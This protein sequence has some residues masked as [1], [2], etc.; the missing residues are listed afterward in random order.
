MS[1][2]NKL[3]KMLEPSFKSKCID[4]VEMEDGLVR[5]S[6]ESLLYVGKIQLISDMLKTT[7][8]VVHECSLRLA[9]VREVF[10]CFKDSENLEVVCSYHL[11]RRRREINLTNEDTLQN[12]NEKYDCEQSQAM[13]D[14]LFLT[15]RVSRKDKEIKLKDVL[16]ENGF[17]QDV[18]E[19]KDVNLK[20]QK[21]KSMSRVKIQDV[22]EKTIIDVLGNTIGKRSINDQ[23]TLDSFDPEIIIE[24]GECVNDDGNTLTHFYLS[25]SIDSVTA[26]HM[27]ILLRSLKYL[28][29][30]MSL[31]VSD[32]VYSIDTEIAA[33]MTWFEKRGGSK[34]ENLLKIKDQID[35]RNPIVRCSLR[36]TV[37]NMDKADIYKLSELA[38]DLFGAPLMHERQVP[39]HMISSTLLGNCTREDLKAIERSRRVLLSTLGNI[40][41]VYTGSLGY[42]EGVKKTSFDGTLIKIDRLSG[43]GNRMTTL[44]GNSGSGKSVVLGD[45]VAEFCQKNKCGLVRVIDRK[46]TLAGLSEVLNGD[47]KRLSESKGVVLSPF[48]IETPDEGDI[49]AIAFL[50]ITAMKCHVSSLNVTALFKE[51]LKEAI[52]ISYG[53]HT[54]DV[55][56][57][58]P[59]PIWQDV[60]SA[61]PHVKDVY[62]SH[63]HDESELDEI[64]RTIKS[65]GVSLESGGQFGQI[66]SGYDY[67]GI[68]KKQ[69]TIYDLDG[70]ADDA[71]RTLMYMTTFIKVMRDIK[72][73]DDSLPKL[74]VF[75]EFGILVNQKSAQLEI[76]DFVDEI[77]KTCRKLNV[78]AIA[79]A[80]D[81]ATYSKSLA[82]RAFW[83]ISTLKIFLPLG[84]LIESIKSDFGDLF[85]SLDYEC[86]EVLTREFDKRRTLIF[87]RDTRFSETDIKR[88]VYYSY[89][90]E[91]FEN[92]MKPRSGFRQ[93]VTSHGEENVYLQ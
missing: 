20:I 8:E 24:N 57:K 86:M 31:I 89:L 84:D 23:A 71:T 76:R 80:N 93:S 19:T 7:E 85:T 14:H 47:V 55:D 11:Q 58:C 5:C 10:E 79:I 27:P 77:V 83:D 63:G 3:L 38:R 53:V 66:F 56:N 67:G 9:I 17:Y 59:H 72:S 32:P 33:K 6:D 26:F 4:L 44:L 48:A 60:L 22:D 25:P 41:P 35:S 69:F 18:L 29:F 90:S 92:V 28:D 42:E 21:L 36:L 15:V 54:Q 91:E 46:T 87:Q 62:L 65:N 70:V 78:Q 12:R 34:Y 45:I 39:V 37:V 50:I 52:R 74:V 81:V 2:I 30:D 64:I 40:L 13:E 49:A 16:R 51:I 68:S 43:D 88:A 75:D 61:L 82:G 73:L 1:S